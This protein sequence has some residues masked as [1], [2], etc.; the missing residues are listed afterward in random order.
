[1]VTQFE[2]IRMLI[3]R[4][5]LT[6]E[7]RILWE[8][9][10]GTFLGSTLLLLGL[11]DCE[12]FAKNWFW[13][14]LGGYSALSTE[15]EAGSFRTLFLTPRQYFFTKIPPLPPKCKVRCFYRLDYLGSSPER[16]KI[17]LQI[18][19]ENLGAVGALS[20]QSIPDWKRERGG[21]RDSSQHLPTQLHEGSQL[22]KR[23]FYKY[24]KC[25]N[26]SSAI[27]SAMPYND[28]CNMFPI[29]RNGGTL[30]N[31]DDIRK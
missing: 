3:S 7:W 22:W 4:P 31:C 16:F 18:I 6:C 1:M 5:R 25:E 29:L 13:G 12:I 15:G 17:Q 9:S 24:I 14:F 19:T 30:S 28:G 8:I 2:W 21:Q 10:R 23:N 11:I 20:I 27:E 26:K